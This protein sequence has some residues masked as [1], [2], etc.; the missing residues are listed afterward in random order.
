M[1]DLVFKLVFDGLGRV[2]RF[3]VSTTTGKSTSITWFSGTD[4]ICS[5][6][7]KK[8]LLDCSSALASIRNVLLKA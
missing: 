3:G 1:I 8:Y 5:E 4:G 7:I 2:S 6:R